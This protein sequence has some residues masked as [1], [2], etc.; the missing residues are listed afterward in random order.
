MEEKKE[1]E[2][3]G[4]SRWTRCGLLRSHSHLFRGGEVPAESRRPLSYV[5]SRS[6]AGDRVGGG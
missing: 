1:L 5:W 3:D 2:V 6:L 4:Y